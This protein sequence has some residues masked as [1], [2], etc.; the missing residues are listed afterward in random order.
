MAYAKLSTAKSFLVGPILDADGVAK[1]DEVVASIKVTKNGVDD[2]RDP[3]STL[4]HSHTGHYVYAAD[5][6]DFDEV[7]EV[8]FSLNSGTNA[9]A[10]VSFTVLTEAID[11]TLE[12]IVADT[13]E[14]QADDT[15]AALAA[16]DAVVDTVKVDT[17]AIKAD[18]ARRTGD[19]S[20]HAAA[21]VVALMLVTPAQKLVTDASGHVTYSN[22]APPTAAQIKTAIEAVGGHLALI[23]ADTNELQADDTPAALAALDAVVDT[24]KVDTAAIQVVTDKLATMIEAAP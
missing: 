20:T 22:A 12:A 24:V 11:T 23:L 19:Y 21:D 10:P 17:A 9:M 8:V 13:D 4:T 1:T 6:D 15:P 7:G 5:T 3:Q 2:T 18:Y 14:L 16:L